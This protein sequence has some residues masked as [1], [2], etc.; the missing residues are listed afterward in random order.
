MSH[1]LSRFWTKN[2]KN[3]L[4]FSWLMEAE[5]PARTIAIV[6]GGKSP[7]TGRNLY[8]AAKALNVSVVV[9]D[10]PGH[11][12]EGPEYADWRAAFL[13]VDRS[14]NARLPDRIV[15]ALEKYSREKGAL[16]I[17][18]LVTFFDPLF[19]GVAAAAK[20]LGLTTP[21]PE[22]YA[23]ATD[24]FK[25]SIAEGRPAYRASSPDEVAKNNSR[26]D[27]ELSTHSQALQRLGLRGRLPCR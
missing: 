12:L 11:W 17:D 19:V 15:E 14:P 25:T 21:S 18:G 13:P 16:K 10:K 7:E 6:E 5:R 8:M 2:W 4:S 22:A 26:Y 20:K 27:P 24:K 23:I 3:R 9:L 1:R